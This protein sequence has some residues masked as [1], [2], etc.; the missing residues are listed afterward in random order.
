MNY[1]SLL[2]EINKLK[3]WLDYFR[4]LSPILVEESKK[5]YDVQFTYNSNAIEGN[6][7]TQ[8]ETELVLSKGITI[9]GRILQEHLEIIGYKEAIYYGNR[10]Y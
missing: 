3:A 8:S 9:C 5:Q 4:L 1:E 7:L 10:S 6:T 2:A